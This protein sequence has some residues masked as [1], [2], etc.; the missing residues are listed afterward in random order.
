MAKIS[1]GGRLRELSA[2]IEGQMHQFISSD[3]KTDAGEDAHWDALAAE[4]REKK[5]KPIFGTVS[6]AV[7]GAYVGKKLYDGTSVLRSKIKDGSLREGAKDAAFTGMRKTAS[8]MNS[9]GNAGNRLSKSI[10][11][12]NGGDLVKKVG[13]KIG[14]G[15]GFLKKSA[16]NLR[17]GSM[18]FFNSNSNLL[19]NL[20]DETG[21]KLA[22]KFFSADLA[23]TMIRIE[24]KVT[25]LESGQVPVEFGSAG[26]HLHELAEIPLNTA[27]DSGYCGDY[28]SSP[29]LNIYRSKEA[30]IMEIP[31]SGTATMKYKLRRKTVDIDKAGVETYGAEI[32]VESI[33]AKKT[34]LEAIVDHYFE[35]ARD[36]GGRYSPGQQ[37][38][39][40]DM[41]AA[42]GGGKK[43]K[44]LIGAGAA[45][46]I[47]ALAGSRNGAVQRTVGNAVGRLVKRSAV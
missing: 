1:K 2:R 47:A 46:G 6:K 3:L 45:T 44:L 26:L 19:V 32:E 8:G 21:K 22:K 35:R 28:G 38:S 15:S 18:K 39:A 16:K 14:E 42:Y 30:R 34:E 13:G 27:S 37:V 24:R 7:G 41:A 25:S 4:Q 5:K 12:G 29:R 36:V 10:G 43:K 17:K 40:D 11:Q 31:A 33:D 20:P 23:A 9:V